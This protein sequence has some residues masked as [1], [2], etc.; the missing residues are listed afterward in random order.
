MKNITNIL[1]NILY[2]VVHGGSSH[3]DE[4]MAVALFMA[5]KAFDND[6]QV[7][8]VKIQRRSPTGDEIRDPNV[9]V[10]DVGG[11]Y[12]PERLTFDHHQFERGTKESA[13]GLFS[14]W[15]GIRDVIGK[16][17]PWFETRVALD[18][19]GPFATAKDAGVDWSTVAK[20]LG[21]WEDM[22]LRK[23]EDAS[24]DDRWEVVAPLARTVVGKFKAYDEVQE[25]LVEK[26][27]EG[28]EVYDFTPC[29]PL[30]AREVSDALV[31]T[32]GVAIFHDDRGAGLTLLR[33]NDDSRI[34]FSR[35]EGD[36]A[37]TFAHKGG[38]IAKTVDKN[39]GEAERLIKM[40]LKS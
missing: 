30:M 33:L 22:I 12:D 28:V 39:L 2:V 31:G 6:G 34:D 7:T 8:P 19:V 1:K 26:D 18:A 38:F 11:V 15:A 25:S 37:V 10:L 14:S 29:D 40:A 21:P 35:C 13:M 3:L 20:F 4:F 36:E 24:D 9:L 23:F 16:L 27:V 17:F 32:R 5:I